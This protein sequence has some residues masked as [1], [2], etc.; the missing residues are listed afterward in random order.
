M[1][2][3]NKSS[4]GLTLRFYSHLNVS[5]VFMFFSFSFCCCCFSNGLY[6]FYNFKGGGG[7]FKNVS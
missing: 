2:Q 1:Q 5:P 3:E 7:K 6:I 4:V